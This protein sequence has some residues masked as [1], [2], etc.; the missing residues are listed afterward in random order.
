MRLHR[1]RGRE[2]GVMVMGTASELKTLAEALLSFTASAP[3]K[4]PEKWPP[5]I[6]RYVTDRSADFLLSFHLDTEAGNEPPSNLP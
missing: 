1:Y 3:E 5:F 4:S 6:T 2:N